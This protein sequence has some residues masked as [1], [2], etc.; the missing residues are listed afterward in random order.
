MTPETKTALILGSLL[1]VVAVGGLLYLARGWLKSALAESDGSASC[2]R[3]ILFLWSVANISAFLAWG[4][5]EAVTAGRM[6]DPSPWGAYLGFS[7]AGGAV[8]YA[9]NQ[10]RRGISER[11]GQPK[12][13]GGA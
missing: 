12:P 4:S 3:L 13:P 1:A 11:N 6:P 7:Q 5:Y 10:M 2:S 8:P 9:F